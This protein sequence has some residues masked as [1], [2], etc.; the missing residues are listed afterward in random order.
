MLRNLIDRGIS[1]IPRSVKPERIREN[2]DIFDFMLEEADMR[3]IR[4]I[5]EDT[6]LLEWTKEL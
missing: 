6:T 4:T 3:K 2:I 5:D 1:A